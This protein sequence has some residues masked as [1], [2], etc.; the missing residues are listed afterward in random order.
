MDTLSL[1]IKNESV[2]FVNGKRYIKA[3]EISVAVCHH[4]NESNTFLFSPNHLSCLNKYMI[5][6]TVRGEVVVYVK[7]I[8]RLQKHEIVAQ[9]AYLPLKKLLREATPEEVRNVYEACCMP[10]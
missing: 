7:E 2:I 10:F 8:R 4:P 6:N 9:K 5:G 1:E 3:P